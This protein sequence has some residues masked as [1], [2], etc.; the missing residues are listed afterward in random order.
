MTARTDTTGSDEA[1]GRTVRQAGGADAEIVATLLAEMSEEMGV[2]GIDGCDAEAL[3]RHGF[4]PAPLFHVML[5]ED[6]RGALGMVLYF[7]EFSTWRG[8]PGVYV[9]D[10]YVRPAARG[11]GLARDLLGAA[12]RHAAEAW[13][14]VYLSL[15]AH[16]T[17][18]RALAFYAK[19]GFETDQGERPHLIGGS[20]FRWLGG[21]Q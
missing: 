12:A 15:T 11:T 18:P 9:Q 16:E 5:A 19:L 21:L 10:L 8:R 7:P 3:R 1:S 4:G 20:A 2:T 13:E 6:A 14:A 17:N